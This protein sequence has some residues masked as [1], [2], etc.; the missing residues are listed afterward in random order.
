M[1]SPTPTIEA[2]SGE[3]AVARGR[4]TWLGRA[5]V[6]A[7]V[8]VLCALTIFPLFW[9]LSTSVKQADEVFTTDIRLIPQTPTLANY[10]DAFDLFP[11]ADW[12]LN[13][14][15]IAGLTTLGK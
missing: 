10:P 5:L 8:L 13:S 4:S 2:R 1:A 7:V 14:F 3:F 9:M 12:F 15:A 6:H 11:V